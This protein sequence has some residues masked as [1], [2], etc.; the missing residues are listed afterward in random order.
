VSNVGALGAGLFATPRVTPPEVG[1]LAL[2]RVRRMPVIIDTG[3]GLGGTAAASEGGGGG[4][5]LL[6]PAYPYYPSTA[7]AAAG[8][9]LPASMMIPGLRGSER[10]EARSVL[11][12]SWGAD[13]RAVDGATLAQAHTFWRQLVEQPERLLLHLR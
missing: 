3:R 9:A 10:L 4:G 7:A 1:I 5:R 2:G 11:G 6:T 13:H 12:V 8:S